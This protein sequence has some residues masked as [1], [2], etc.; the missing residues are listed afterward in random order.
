MKNN[1]GL[2]AALLV[3]LLKK[4]SHTPSTRGLQNDY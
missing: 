1:L 4:I 3:V 2:I